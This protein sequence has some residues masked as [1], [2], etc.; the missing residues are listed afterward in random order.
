MK[1]LDLFSGIGGFRSGL[2]RAGHECVGY[3][4]IDK[5]ARKS[6]EAIYDT[7]GEWTE[8]DITTVRARDIPKSDIWT[9]GFP[10]QDISV[11]G[12]QTGFKGSRSS[13]F[14]TVTGLIRDLKEENK[15]SILLIENVKNLLSVNRGYD[16]LKLL[17]ELDE[18]GYDAEW[19]VLDTAEVL[20]QH[21]ERV[22]IIGHFRG[23][24]GRKI[25][26]IRRNDGKTSKKYEIN[27]IGT[28]KTE[29]AQGA[30]SRSRVYA[31]GHMSTLTATDYKQPKQIA[32]NQIGNIVKDGNF[33]NPQRGRV[34]SV[35]GLCPALN[36]MRGGGLEPK[37]AVPVI[38]PDRIKKGQN[39]RRFKTNDEPMF[40]LNTQDRHGVAILQRSRGANKGGIKKIVSPL[41]KSSYQESN[42]MLIKEATKK[43]FAEATIGDSVNI[44]QP[45][46]KTRRGRV[47][48]QKANTLETS[49]NQGVVVPGLRIRKLT[50]LE[51]WRLQG[52]TDEQFYKAQAVNSNSQLYK[53]AGNSVTVDVVFEIAKGI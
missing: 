46:S 38:T 19:D 1:F 31:E 16:F 47:G 10:C 18:I 40:T 20:P 39:G 8:H 49:L 27:I 3:V 41:S 48:N 36:C 26:P 28:T 2:E 35:D 44:S 9:F 17:I 15:P 12:K 29:D 30:N 5:F 24:S 45:N 42:L 37:I 52:F 21:R 53:Q 7:K 25:F 4:E 23:R 11:A 32:V 13:L 51:C 50:P 6:Y 14:F 34:Y 22:F 33:K 43:G